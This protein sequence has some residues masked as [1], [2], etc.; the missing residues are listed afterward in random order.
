MGYTNSKL[1]TVK[2]LSPNHSGKRTHSIDRITPHCVVGQLSAAGIG[3]CFKK[4]SR[5]ASCNY[6]IGTKGDV[7]LVV[8]EKNRSWCSSSAANDQRAIT[9]ECAS[10]TKDP[11]AVNSAVWNMLVKLCVDICKRNGKKKLLWLGSK[12][13]TLKYNPKSGEMV[14]SAHRWFK[15]KAC[16]GQYLYSRFGKLAEEVT[17]QLGGS[18][19]T[20]KPKPSKSY[21]VKI[22]ANTLN[23][24]KQPTVNSKIVTQ[25]HKG[26]VYTIVKTQNG[27]GKLKSGAGW[28][29]LAYTKKV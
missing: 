18:T 22:T 23:V 8:E 27:W 14:L 16:P 15:N 21:K 9:I 29:N 26:Q 24:R 12:D 10:D 4:S 25:V 3:N 7:V 13:K 20:P 1:A 6:G 19:P 17:K 5:Q 11:Y 28:I 2:C